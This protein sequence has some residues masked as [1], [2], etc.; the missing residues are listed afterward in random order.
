[1]QTPRLP[2]PSLADAKLWQAL[3]P[4]FAVLMSRSGWQAEEAVANLPLRLAVRV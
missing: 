1:L 4:G 3:W 2:L